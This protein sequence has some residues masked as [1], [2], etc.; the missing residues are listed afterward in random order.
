MLMIGE[1]NKEQINAFLIKCL[2]YLEDTPFIL[3]LYKKDKQWKEKKD[4]A[5]FKKIVSGMDAVIQRIKPVEK[6]EADLD[7]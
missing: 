3:D 1:D 6:E 7:M 5:N 2:Y 4:W